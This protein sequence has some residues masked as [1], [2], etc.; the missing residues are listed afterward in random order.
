MS[1]D[2]D[3]A[4]IPLRRRSRAQSDSGGA[5]AALA[6]FPGDVYPAWVKACRRLAGAGYGGTIAEDY[7]RISPGI[8]RLAGARAALDLV[9]VVSGLA[10]RAGRD[11]AARFV[12]ASLIAAGRLP[13]DLGQ[14]S[15]IIERTAVQAP[16]SMAAILERTETLLSRLDLVALESWLRIG[17]RAASGD[18]Q[19]RQRF[20]TLQ[21]PEAQRWLQRESGVVG[22][23]DIEGRPKPF[24][25]ALWGMRVPLREVPADAP[26]QVKRRAGFD[27]AVMRLP[28]SFPGFSAVDSQNLYRAAV[29]HIGAHCVFT[30]QKFAVGGLKPAQVALVSL[31][32]DAR[33]DQLAMRELPGLLRLFLPFHT[34]PPSGPAT[35]EGLFARLSRALLDGDHEDSDGRVRKGRDAFF[36]AEED[37]RSSGSAAASVTCSATISARC[38]SSSIQGVTSSSR[39]IATTIS[40]SGISATKNS[41]C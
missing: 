28:A 14:G 19:R 38:A 17:I 15:R 25:T 21:D 27:G 34:A 4:L 18:P 7:V 13:D 23:L 3:H 2:D 6:A 20:F 41:R 32:E 8:D 39:P 1:G 35:A 31:I 29:A 26:E 24:L 11:A 9:S 33:V 37:W 40:V 5:A 12:P 10:I 36:A 30:R 16:E 22:F